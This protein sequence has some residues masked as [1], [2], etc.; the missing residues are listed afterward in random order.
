MS[1]YLDLLQYKYFLTPRM[2]W[3][4]GYDFLASAKISGINS[5]GNARRFAS[6]HI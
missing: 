5:G 1:V 2:L 4:H 3:N 6:G